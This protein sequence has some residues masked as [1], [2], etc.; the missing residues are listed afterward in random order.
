MRHKYVIFAILA[1]A[2]S[3]CATPH[4][5]ESVKQSDATLTCT[6]ISEEI[7][8]ADRFRREA[9]KE[10]GMTGTNV[11]AVL[12]FWPAMIGTYSNANEAIAAAD[13]RKV[14]LIGFF[15]QKKCMEE[16]IS[17]QAPLP[18]HAGVDDVLAVPLVNETGRE[19]YR[20]FLTKG[21]P[22]AFAIASNG[23]WSWASG[24][25][26]ADATM[27]VDP[28]ERALEVCKRKGHNNCHIYAVDNR[29]IWT[30]Q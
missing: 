26:P 12:F 24:K 21:Y 2:L 27:P 11:A 13:S 1:A 6:Q 16:P 28:S 17:A 18:D 22:R 29:V 7:R 15:N 3:G 19:G 9:Q 10:K 30:G 4:V 14:S 23:G 20:V 25:R 5:V 8:Q